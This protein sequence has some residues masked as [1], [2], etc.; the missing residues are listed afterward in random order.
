METREDSVVVVVSTL[1]EILE[2]R[3]V[4][5]L[6]IY[7]QVSVST[8]LEILALAEPSRRAPRHRYQVVST[9]LE[10]LGRGGSDAEGVEYRKVVSTLLEI[11]VEE[12]VALLKGVSERLRFNPS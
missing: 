6:R 1:L 7:M 2:Q 4:R 3:R 12:M 11:L 10:I 9:L 8:L 5:T